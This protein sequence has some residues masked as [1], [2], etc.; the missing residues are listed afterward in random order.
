MPSRDWLKGGSLA[1]HWLRGLTNE[2]HSQRRLAGKCVDPTAPLTAARVSGVAGE[3]GEQHAAA[4]MCLTF[5]YANWVTCVYRYY[6]FGGN[7]ITGQAGGVCVL[8][9]GPFQCGY[10]FLFVCLFVLCKV[11]LYL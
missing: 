7:N 9:P 5:W 6:T 11:V 3:R 2:R 4:G 10:V 1:P 8:D